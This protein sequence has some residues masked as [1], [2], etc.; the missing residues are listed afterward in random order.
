[1][2]PRKYSDPNDHM[3]YR[4]FLRSR[5]Q[6]WYLDQEWTL[7]F[8]QYCDFWTPALW[9]LRGRGTNDLVMVRKDLSGPWSKENCEI[10]TRKEQLTRTNKKTK[11]D[12]ETVND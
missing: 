9:S 3:R 7:T 8:K 4:P 11:R 1:M 2:K 6:A 12:K 5:S 10:V